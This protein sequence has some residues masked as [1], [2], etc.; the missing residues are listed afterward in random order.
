L[1]LSRQIKS[2]KEDVFSH[3]KK[4]EQ[5]ESELAWARDKN[6]RLED[7]LHSA[8]IEIKERAESNARLE[9]KAG[10]QQQAMLELERV[11]KTLTAQLFDLRQETGPREQ[12]LSTAE[13]RLREV[14]REYEHS[15]HA[16]SDKDTSIAQQNKRIQMLHRQNRDLRFGSAK[17]EQVLRRAATQLTAFKFAFQHASAH[18]VRRSV[19]VGSLDASGKQET[20]IEELLVCSEDMNVCLHRLDEILSPFVS[21]EAEVAKQLEM[22]VDEEVVDDEKERHMQLL[23][24]TVVSLQETADAKDRVTTKHILGNIAE[25]MD[26]ITEVNALRKEVRCT[27]YLFSV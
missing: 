2:L 7:A 15:L 1:L 16:M 26:L 10:D 17:K 18:S 8:T 24:R 9:F 6:G 5:L 13:A 11:R 19:Q 27:E 4:N 22:L 21:S 25:N 3:Q 23:G 14:E 12:L 20:K